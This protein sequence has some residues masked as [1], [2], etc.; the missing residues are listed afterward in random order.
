MYS[1]YDK[2]ALV[3]FYPKSGLML[4]NNYTSETFAKSQKDKYTIGIW[5]IKQ[6]KL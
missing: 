2:V 5:R 4:T 3:Q 1:K 6:Q